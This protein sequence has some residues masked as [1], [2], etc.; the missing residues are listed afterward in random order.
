LLIGRN[1]DVLVGSGLFPIAHKFNLADR[2]FFQA[3]REAPLEVYLSAVFNARYSEARAFS[4]AK[5]RAGPDGHFGGIISVGVSPEYFSGFH[6][7][8]AGSNGVVQLVRVD[9]QLIIGYPPLP[10]PA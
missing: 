10:Q 8:L 6:Q 1:G 3:L 7:T 2:D 9:G 5:R 4:V